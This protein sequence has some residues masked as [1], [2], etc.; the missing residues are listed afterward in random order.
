[1]ACT[2]SLPSSTSNSEI[3]PAA[4]PAI[5]RNISTDGSLLSAR[6][7]RAKGPLPSQDLTR[8]TNSAPYPGSA[9]D[10]RLLSQDTRSTAANDLLLP[11]EPSTQPTVQVAC[12]AYAMSATSS[13]VPSIATQ[14]DKPRSPLFMPSSVSSSPAQMDVDDAATKARPLPAADHRTEAPVRANRGQKQNANLM[15]GRYCQKLLQSSDILSLEETW[16]KWP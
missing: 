8:P 7:S 1:V 13:S 12:S 16:R 11:Q 3:T 9:L 4:S 10:R 15:V 6:W 14:I 2:N 5:Q